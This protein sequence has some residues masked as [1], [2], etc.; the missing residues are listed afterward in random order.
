MFT[1]DR[2]VPLGYQQL[3]PLTTATALTVPPGAQFCWMK[4]TGQN[5]RWRDDGT[6]PTSTVGVLMQTTD[7]AIWY[8]GKLSKLKFIQVSATAT[9]DVLYYG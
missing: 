5:V 1:R 3:T 4:C 9:L 7:H 2:V 6:N 8:A